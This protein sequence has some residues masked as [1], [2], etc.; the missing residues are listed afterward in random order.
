MQMSK[1]KIVPASDVSSHKT[2][3]I[4]GLS[5]TQIDAILGFRPNVDDDPHKVK[6]SWA[7]SVQGN[8]CAVWDY[9]GSHKLKEY[10]AYGPDSVLREVFGSNY[11]SG[12]Y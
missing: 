12:A 11:L 6:Y 2:G 9:K 1:L 10:S 4:V 8:D 7:F 3:R 5:K